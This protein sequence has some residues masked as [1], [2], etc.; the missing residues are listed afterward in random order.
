M[1]TLPDDILLEIFDHYRLLCAGDWPRLQG[2]YKLAHM[3]R[4]WRRL[5]FASS[6]RLN[7]QLR[8]T[9]R[10]QVVDMINHSPPFPLVL[11]YG[12]RLL[13]TWTPEDEDGLL[14]AFLH[15]S[16]ANEIMLSAPQ[17][18]LAEM[19]AAMVE[20]APRLEHLTLH[21]QS[22][23]FVL[24]KSFLDGDAPQLR[25]LILAG[26]SLATLHPLL[27]SATSLVSLVLERVPPSAYF[28]PDGLVAHIRSMPHLQ[29]LSIGFLFAVPRPGFRGERFLP[30]GQI[31]RVE[32]PALTQL[33][34]RG[35]STYIEALLARIRTPLVQDIDITLFNQLTLRLPRI[36]AYI[37]DLESFQPTRARV[38]FAESSAHVIVV[39]A[40]APRPS[41]TESPDVSLSVSCARLDF[42]V[43][44]MAQICNSLSSTGAGVPVHYLLPI[45]ELTLGFHQGDQ[46]PPAERRDGDEVVVDPALWRAL[47]SPFRRVRTL[48]VHVAL[49]ALLE[50]ALRSRPSD[51]PAALSVDL[52]TV[53]LLHGDRDDERAMLASASEA[54]DALVDERNRA[55]HPAVVATIESGD[56]VV[57]SA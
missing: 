9:F 54:L 30:P 19:T 5:V 22:A 36:S 18:T 50:S 17:S 23:E 34:Y 53:V 27:P 31:P 13:K 48:R 12:P 35:V 45:E 56:D 26:V 38:D 16:R 25:H 11:D 41:A 28:S 39:S 57:V 37:H 21:S 43:S 20:A 52:R 15:L 6:L 14:F 24:P 33:I 46:P 7:L 55:G 51:E 32:L 4:R 40:P 8:C 2:W 44:A 1:D 10:T 29:T 49:A 3:C 42:Q 47:L